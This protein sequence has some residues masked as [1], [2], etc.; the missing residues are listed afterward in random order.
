MTPK[1]QIMRKK[2]TDLQAVF[3][4]SLHIQEITFSSSTM[5]AYMHIMDNRPTSMPMVNWILKSF[6][7][8]E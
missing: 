3:K 7:N 1:F 4:H 6:K 5:M 2:M 8:L